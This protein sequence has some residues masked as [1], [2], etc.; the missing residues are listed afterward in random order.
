M[1]ASSVT[2]GT[3]KVTGRYSYRRLLTN[4]RHFQSINSLGLTRFEDL[5]MTFVQASPQC[6]DKGIALKNIIQTISS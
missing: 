2:L 6:G 1:V 5:I 3:V 4:A